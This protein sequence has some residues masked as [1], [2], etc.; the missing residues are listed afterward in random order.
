MLTLGGQRNHRNQLLSHS[1][2]ERLTFVQLSLQRHPWHTHNTAV[3]DSLTQTYKERHSYLFESAPHPCLLP[4][5][6]WVAV[7]RNVDKKTKS[8]CAAVY[9]LRDSPQS[10]WFLPLAPFCTWSRCHGWRLG[11]PV[12]CGFCQSERWCEGSLSLCGTV[13]YEL[14]QQ[15]LKSSL[16]PSGGG[17][18]GGDGAE[19][20][21]CA[22]QKSACVTRGA[23]CACLVAAVTNGLKHNI[24]HW[25]KDWTVDLAFPASCL[26]SNMCMTIASNHSPGT[27]VSQSSLVQHAPHPS[28]WYWLYCIYLTCP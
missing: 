4:L 17:R 12:S 16:V 24:F 15:V 3:P 7:A 19:G 1:G 28:P 5:C 20:G 11:S 6:W 25:S 2:S 23:I 21:L 18:G 14:L 27:P 8:G 22:Q 13:H 9:F 26:C 10:T